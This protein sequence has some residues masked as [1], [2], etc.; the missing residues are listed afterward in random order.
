MKTDVFTKEIP[1][2]QTDTLVSDSN[3]KQHGH[4]TVLGMKQIKKQVLEYIN[5]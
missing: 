3:K 1:A 4:P 2:M 5:M